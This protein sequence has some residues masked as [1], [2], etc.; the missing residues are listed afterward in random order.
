MA[1]CSDACAVIRM[2]G[3]SG[4]CARTAERISMPVTPGIFTSVR[5][6]SGADPLSCSRPALPPWAVVTSKPSFLSRMRSV[7]RMPCSS[8]ITRMDGTGALMSGSLLFA[9][10]GGEVHGEGR[11]VPRLAVDEHQA[12]V[13]FHRA[14][15]DGEAEPG[16]A[17]PARRK[18][19]EQ[20]GLQIV[21][22]AGAVVAHA[23]GHGVL[24]TGAA[25]QLVQ[26]RPAG[27][28]HDGG[29]FAGRLDGVQHEVRDHAV[30]E[31]LV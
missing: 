5:T 17:Y 15:H 3:V 16:A 27:P 8:S 22:D 31:I 4:S 1:L 11:P 24:D 21:G 14:L 23:Q 25:G 18:R 2:T 13:G 28:H 9:A 19:L 30:Q 7:S 12:A 10:G 29:P 26:R 20:A 6:M